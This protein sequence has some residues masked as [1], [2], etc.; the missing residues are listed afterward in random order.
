MKHRFHV[1]AILALCAAGCR[2][3]ND[4][5]F[6]GETALANG[7]TF[8]GLV[9]N[10]GFGVR[11]Q[12]AVD[13]ARAEGSVLRGKA[14]GYLDWSGDAGDAALEGS[15]ERFSRIDLSA[16]LEKTYSRYRLIGSIDNFNFPNAPATSTTELS[17][18]AE[19]VDWK[20][21]PRAV[22]HYDIQ[23]ADDLYFRLGLHPRHEFDRAL[24][25]DVGLDVGYMGGGQAEFY[26]GVDESG[27]SDVLLSSKLTYVRDE[28]FHAFI[29]LDATQVLSSDL[30]D[31]N[32]LNG[33]DDS[34][35]VAFLGCGWTY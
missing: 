24:F 6:R 35:F 28:H 18:G 12:A 19:R 34:S 4:S 29:G 21:R 25:A 30:K 10:E 31:Q 27:L 32:S 23:N 14:W 16:E 7:Y 22:L 17:F 20:L 9:M 3:I 8:R 13:L 2:S 11:T 5:T 15:E 33:F 26:Y 1:I